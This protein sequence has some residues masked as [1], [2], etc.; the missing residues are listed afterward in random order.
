MVKKEDE[1][2]FELTVYRHLGFFW[3]WL[4]FA[5]PLAGLVWGFV[6]YTNSALVTC[7]YCIKKILIL[8]LLRKK[9]CR[10][11]CMSFFPFLSE[12]SRHKLGHTLTKIDWHEWA[13]ISQILKHRLLFTICKTRSQESSFVEVFAHLE[14]GSFSIEVWW[15]CNFLCHLYTRLLPRTVLGNVSWSNQLLP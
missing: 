5:Y 1:E 2:H 8:F 9:L 12:D 6:I 15:I 11:G 4:S 14:C 3:P 13:S 10:T 7:Y